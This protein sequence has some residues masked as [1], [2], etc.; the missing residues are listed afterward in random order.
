[1]KKFMRISLLAT[2]SIAPDAVLAFKPNPQEKV[3]V[4]NPF[5]NGQKVSV[6]GER[7]LLD[8]QAAT[9]IGG[10]L[11]FD[12]KDL[13]APSAAVLPKA[14]AAVSDKTTKDPVDDK[15]ISKFA[16][17]VPEANEAQKTT[18]VLRVM[19]LLNSLVNIE[20]QA[21]AVQVQDVLVV[22]T[23]P[24]RTSYYK[25]DDISK[26]TGANFEGLDD[27]VL[28]ALVAKAQDIQQALN[29]LGV[30]IDVYELLDLPSY[31]D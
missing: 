24:N 6:A 2:A 23:V 16:E 31:A 1:M 9:F 7:V 25:S 18:K 14:P 30:L 28:K 10:S 21:R 3:L 13:F 4:M 20:M 17:A 27:F 12:I 8:E 15:A 11:H 29:D 26:L 5:P 19:A 22:T